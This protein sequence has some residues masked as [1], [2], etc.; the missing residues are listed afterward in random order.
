MHELQ[1]HALEW[2]FLFPQLG[3]HL[4]GCGYSR[5]LESRPLFSVHILT[6]DPVVFFMRPPWCVP[7][8]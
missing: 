3:P 4:P 5:A 2:Q 1:S 7:V 8:R 6:Y